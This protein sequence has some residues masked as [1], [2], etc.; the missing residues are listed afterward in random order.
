MDKHKVVDTL[1]GVVQSFRDQFA[2][3]DISAVSNIG[4]AAK[5]GFETLKA[6][7]SGTE[8]DKQAITM[9]KTYAENFEDALRKHNRDAAMQALHDME[10]S[11]QGFRVH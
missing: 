1:E 8:M 10:K 3:N 2:A 4:N 5:L 6:I 11:I 9:F 7:I